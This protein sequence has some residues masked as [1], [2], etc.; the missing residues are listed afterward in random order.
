MAEQQLTS[1][2]KSVD[3]IDLGNQMKMYEQKFQSSHLMPGLPIVMRFDGNAFHTFT[4][5]M[6]KP[7]DK[8]LAQ[9]FQCTVDE[10]IKE[11]SP[12]LVYHQSD[13]ISLFWFNN[14]TTKQ[15]PFDGKVQKWLSVYAAKCTAIFNHYLL[16]FMEHKYNERPVFDARVF[17]LPRWDIAYDY[18]M[19]RQMDARRNS[20]S[21]AAS[22]VYPESQ[23][24][25]KTTAERIQL[26]HEKGI[27]FAD[28]P[29]SFRQGTF[30][31]KFR[32]EVEIDEHTWSLIPDKNKPE[33]R[34]V[35]RTFIDIINNV[36]KLVPGDQA[37]VFQLFHNQAV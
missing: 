10:L 19:W 37:T 31:R 23:L 33:S 30:T 13:E 4:N 24:L 34:M 22:S 6:K 1:G 29:E 17:Q 15:L 11:L 27:S 25:G 35:K 21:M 2:A 9:V 3:F 16:A 14:D 8:D 26:L 28:Y 20:V 36:P 7:Y 12:D 32:R 5:G 18:F